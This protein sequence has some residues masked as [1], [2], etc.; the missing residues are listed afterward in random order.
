[1]TR[2]RYREWKGRISR[3]LRKAQTVGD[4]ARDLDVSKTA[5]ATIALI[6]GIGVQVLLAGGHIS[7]KRQKALVDLFIETLPVG[8]KPLRKARVA[9]SRVNGV[10]TVI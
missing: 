10:R 9:E 5:D 7:P 2:D 3:L 1:V 8:A 6:D 4:L